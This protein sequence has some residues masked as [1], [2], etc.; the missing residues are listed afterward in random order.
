MNNKKNER[1]IKR[2]EFILK[3]SDCRQTPVFKN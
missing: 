3:F 1:I 2:R